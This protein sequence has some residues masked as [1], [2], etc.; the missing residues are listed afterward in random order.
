MGEAAGAICTKYR[1]S[2]YLA[3]YSKVRSKVQG[4]GSP[5]RVWWVVWGSDN[6]YQYRLRRKSSQHL[7]WRL[8]RT[9]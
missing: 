9:D 1:V 8:L 2:R 5:G 7:H 4:L 6:A 3:T